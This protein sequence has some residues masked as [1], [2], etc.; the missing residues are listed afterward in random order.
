VTDHGKQESPPLSSPRVGGRSPSPSDAASDLD[1][2]ARGGVLVVLAAVASGLLGFALVVAVSRGL[3][4]DRAGRFFEAVALFT[5]AGNLLLLGSDVG[6][7][8]TIARLRALGRYEDLRLTLLVAMVPVFLV[9]A[10]L[11]VGLAVLAEPIAGLLGHEQVDELARA[12]KDLAPFLPLFAL[13]TAG[14]AATQGFGTM[15]PTALVDRVGR[16]AFQ[17]ALVAVAVGAGSMRMLAVA[18]GLP[19]A[20]A[21]IV[22]LLWVAVLLWRSERSRSLGGFAPSTQ[23]RRTVAS[24]GAEFWR[25]SLAR[26]LAGIFQV[27]SAWLGTLLVGAFGTSRQ[28][29]VFTASSRY[30]LVGTFTA[31]AINLT[32]APQI[33]YLLAQDRRDRVHTVFRTATWWLVG[34]AWPIYLLLAIFAPLL[35]R[36]FGASFTG[37][38]TV[39][40]IMSIAMLIVVATGPVDIVL[41]MGGKSTWNLINTF[42]AL[43]VQATLS[44]LLIP[45]YGINGAAIGWAAGIL[46]NNLAPAIEVWFIFRV[47][48]FGGEFVR[49]ALATTWYAAIGIP[50][51]LIFGA[52]VPA[53]LATGAAGTVLFGLYLYGS[54]D[55]L[56][57]KVL[58]RT[59]RRT[60]PEDVPASIPIR[61]WTDQ[62]VERGRPRIVA[63]AYACEPERGSE[64]GAGWMWARLLAELGDVWILT[65][66][67]HR[68][69]I[70][71][72]L[73]QAPERER[74]HFLYVDL[75]LEARLSKRRKRTPRAAI[76][77]YFHYFAWQ[78]VASR[79]ARKLRPRIQ[80]DL[81]WHLTFASAWMGSLAPMAAKTFVYGPVGGG[82]GVPWRLL[83]STGFA[84]T[85]FELRRQIARSL[86]RYLNPLARLAWNRASLILVQNPETRAW[87]P[88]RHRGKALVFPN[89]VLDELPTLTDK[90]STGPPVALYAGRLI[91]WKGVSLALEAIARTE[92]WTLL[93]CGDGPDE[94]RLRLMAS[95]LR[96]AERVQF[97]G[98]QSRD[99]VFHLMESADAFLFASLHDDGGWVVVEAMGCGLPVV[100]LDRGGPPGLA[101]SEGQVVRADLPRREVVALLADRLDQLR[102]RASGP[103]QRASARAKDF[104]LARVSE[105]LA[106]LLQTELGDRVQSS[107][108]SSAISRTRG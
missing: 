50:L 88:R 89:I 20:L 56:E 48:P 72:G 3:S 70:E 80:F 104:T 59:M 41:L 93:I 100:C 14:V 7:V 37:G 54:R 2:L 83:P 39:I 36:V 10:G 6:L 82:V 102:S 101:G 12:I 69:G 32:I 26:G 49:L 92:D 16:P 1:T 105:R 85:V 17:L 98:W 38:G 24:M 103:S 75:P 55:A 42:V 34:S 91:P 46:V 79:R 81:A 25:F 23:P 73:A 63:F 58:F 60:P 99:T 77:S 30:I 21:S 71:A 86:G 45:R 108:E 28:A 57:L 11:A 4:A 5:V 15:L 13:L 96:I 22:T 29:A 78:V 84:G 65:R 35:V 18:W 97:L 19:I 51:R 47:H 53:L 8:R 43:V 76:W 62:G 61:P 64:P 44:V 74:M 67:R 52:S 90:S 68:L 107:E 40:I 33:S 9:G 27:A 95:R 31:A 106:G 66:T 94:R 87:L